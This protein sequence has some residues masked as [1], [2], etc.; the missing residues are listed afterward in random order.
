LYGR[1]CADDKAGIVIHAASVAAWKE[2]FGAPPVN[3]KVLLEG[4]EEAG[5]AGLE[6]FCQNNK[7]LL[8]CDVLV[9]TDCSNFAPGT[10]GITTSLRGLVEFELELQSLQAPVHS[11]MWGGPVPDPVTALCK[12]ISGLTDE[13]GR[14][15][16]HELLATVRP[17]TP[18]EEATLNKLPYSAKQFR[19]EVGLLPE[20]QILAED[21]KILHKIWREPSLTVH[22]IEAG[23][24]GETGNTL[25]DKAWCRL[26]VRLAPGMDPS[27]T[28]KLITQKI[29]ELTPW[30]LKCK[31]ES[32][33]AN[34]AWFTDVTHPY[35]ELA[36]NAWSKAFGQSAVFMGCGGSIPF[37]E[38]LSNAL[39][40]IPSLLVGVEDPYTLAHSENESLYIPDFHRAVAAQIEFYNMLAKES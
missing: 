23:K 28:Q 9:L 1:G 24:R 29:H 26:T 33:T 16:I 37:V 14:P 35:F 13:Q 30:G 5:S 20:V 6:A 11:G 34:P 10:P 15:N 27:L 7:E 19:H 4:E 31:V 12:I 25:M 8:R 39:G 40:G 32:P 36:Q 38:H 21:S 18:L 3:I 2:T 17:P 22:I